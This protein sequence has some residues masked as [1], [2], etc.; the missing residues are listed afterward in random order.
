METEDETQ[1][2]PH[3]LPGPEWG[4]R[5]SETARGALSLNPALQA[6]GLRGRRATGRQGRAPK[7]GTSQGKAQT[8]STSS[9]AYQ[10]ASSPQQQGARA[11]DTFMIEKQLQ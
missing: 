6:P 10:G 8:D 9:P 5:R 11:M 1:L 2:L 4:H 7:W 3:Y